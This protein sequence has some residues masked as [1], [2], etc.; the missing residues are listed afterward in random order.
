MAETSLRD[1]FL[2]RRYSAKVHPVSFDPRN[3]ELQS[4][5]FFLFF[6]CGVQ[7]QV[8]NECLK[9]LQPTK[10]AKTYM[11]EKASYRE[12]PNSSAPPTLSNNS[13]PRSYRTCM[14]LATFDPRNWEFR[15]PTS[16]NF[17][18]MV[19]NCYLSSDIFTNVCGSAFLILCK[20]ICTPPN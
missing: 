6:S 1:K 20:L 16:C 7:L 5:A 10:N 17:F 13:S 9:D 4:S 19:L 12:L 2:P 14:Q 8:W 3:W 18:V 11:A 15:Y